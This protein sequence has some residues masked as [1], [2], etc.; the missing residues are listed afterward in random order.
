MDISDKKQIMKWF[1]QNLRRV[2]K[3]KGYSQE[4]LAET[5]KIDQSFYG[6]VERGEK[7]ITVQKLAQI[8]YALGIP[9]KDLFV[10]EPKRSLDEKEKE[11]EKLINILR[12]RSPEDLAFISDILFRMID[13]KTKNN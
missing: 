3:E 13:W 9:M 7:S 1:G 6:A 8:T 4:G 12:E 10:A 5:A 11:F 2:R